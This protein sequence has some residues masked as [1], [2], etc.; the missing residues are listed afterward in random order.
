MKIALTIGAAAILLTGCAAD[1]MRSYI[2]QDIRTVELDS[3]PP[4]N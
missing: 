4:A 3:G 2:G 1:K